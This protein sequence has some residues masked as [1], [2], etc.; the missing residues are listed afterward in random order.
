M[1][2]KFND[3]K[4]INPMSYNEYRQL[5]DDL[6]AKGKTTGTNHS[7]DMIHYT[8]M[9]VTRMSRID[10]HISLIPELKSKIEAINQPQTWVV[11]TEAWCGDAAQIVPLF[12]KMARLNENIKLI[13]VLRDENIELIDDYLTNGGRSI[14]KIIV[15]DNSGS[16][17]FNWGPRPA[18]A[19]K[20]VVEMKEQKIPLW[21]AATKLH[22]W[23]AKDKTLSTQK[24]LFDHFSKVNEP[25]N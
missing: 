2:K 15:F 20:L 16:E 18:D 3:Y 1:M 14:P 12:D 6:L 17:R 13:L 7:E 9:N 5:T 24:E 19:Q 23:Y 21:D 25:V 4:L 11:I 8:K 10:K 22:G